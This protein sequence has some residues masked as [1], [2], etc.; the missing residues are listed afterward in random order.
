MLFT[1]YLAV[2]GRSIEANVAE[3]FLEEPEPIPRIIELGS[4]VTVASFPS[5]HRLDQKAL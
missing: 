4:V 2:L 1:G 5:K 3:V